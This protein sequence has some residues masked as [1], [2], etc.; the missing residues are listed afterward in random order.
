MKICVLAKYVPDTEAKISI[1]ADKPNRIDE[2]EISFIIN[3]YDEYAVEEAL[4]IAE[5]KDGETTVIT[6]GPPDASGALRHSLAMGIE[7]A[8][9][10]VDEEET[11]PYRTACLLSK[12]LKDKE[13]D[14]FLCGKAAID[15]DTSAVGAILAEMLKIPQVLVVTKIEIS[16]DG[17]S[18]VCR[19]DIEGGTM[20]VETPLPA[21]LSC[22]KGLNEPR[23][24]TIIDIKRANKKTI[25]TIEAKACSDETAGLRVRVEKFNSPPPRP[26][27]RVLGG[28][29]ATVGKELAR[30]L[31]EE[32]KVL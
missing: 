28:D 25:E 20:V 12:V 5:E 32:A 3:P 13:F 8:I 4:T 9:H 31:R 1:L 24:P 11:D 18:A 14:L 22:Q 26:V 19:R 16:E 6:M 17:K 27:G 30:L 21:V 15:D 7:N 23:L 2:S 10:V 29:A